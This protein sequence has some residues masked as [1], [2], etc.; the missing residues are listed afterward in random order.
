METIEPIF[1]GSM[2]A[3]YEGCDQLAINL[4]EELAKF[5]GF[6]A[7]YN[8]TFVG[9]FK[10]MIKNARDL[11]DEEQRS[12]AH[13][14]KRLEL[15]QITDND[16]RKALGAL[17]L[18][19]RDTYKDAAVREVMLED[20]GYRDYEDALHYNWEKL[21]TL[22]QKAVQFVTS[23]EAELMANDNMPASFKTDL[24]DIRDSIDAKVPVFLNEKENTSQGTQLK[25]EASNAVYRAAIGICEDGQFVFT[26]NPAKHKQFVWESI[27]E[28]VTPPGRAGLKFDVKAS[29][30]NAPIAGATVVIQT[31]AK[32][33][34][35]VVT[36]ELGK[37]VF[38]NLAVGDYTGSVT[39]EG[40][41]PLSVSFTITTGTTSFKHWVMNPSA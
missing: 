34:E 4:E 32:E 13:E 2:D 15:V 3:L 35:Q 28:L 14:L 27:M 26:N 33:P 12:T 37:G 17:R 23:H 29:G 6:K 5:A 8:P 30:T 19:M 24:S 16:V 36:N 20:A 18:Y 7:K 22:L 1:R 31:A 21:R 25:L 11:P 10:L 41:E 40:F 38:D 9:D 39:K